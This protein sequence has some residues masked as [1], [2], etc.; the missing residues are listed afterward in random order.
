MKY[1]VFPEENTR[2]R[3]V[4]DD[5]FSPRSGYDTSNVN[6][7]DKKVLED[8]PKKTSKK[9]KKK[10]KSH[11]GLGLSIYSSVLLLICLGVFLYFYNFIGAYEKSQTKYGM[12][13][14][15]ADFKSGDVTTL[16]DA[17][18]ITSLSNPTDFFEYI[19]RYNQYISGKDIT[20][21]KSSDYT[22][23]VPAF[24]VLADGVKCADVTLSS[25]K[26]KGYNF[27]EWSF[28]HMSVDNYS[29]L[30][31]EPITIQVQAPEGST[32]SINGTDLA[33]DKIASINNLD[34]LVGIKEHTPELTKYRMYEITNLVTEPKVEVRVGNDKKIV[35][36]VND[37][38]VATDADMDAA[39]A[40]EMKE[41]SEK[42][43]KSYALKFVGLQF[44]I[45]NYVMP[46]SGLRK[47]ISSAITSFYPTEYISSH[48]F[49]KLEVKN[50]IKYN[51]NVFSCEAEYDLY[52]RF[53]NYSVGDTNE[54][55]HFY[56]YFVKKDNKWYLTVIE[57]IYD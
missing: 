36:K 57:Y 34:W 17:N 26:M 5:V 51:E 1:D 42:V 14:V 33:S 11:F 22:D 55:G 32:I 30:A 39:F 2:K 38:Y 31:Y 48:E 41:Y 21:V 46:N 47:T 40:S 35:N 28:E 16:F 6:S 3:K 9:H 52:L 15:I 29:T 13:E 45:N 24:T 7:E 20:F 53:K 54:T 19:S 23:A 12:D 27:K 50:F 44:D 4:N 8:I 49:K 43:L 37:I 25:H 18:T 56:M 10:K